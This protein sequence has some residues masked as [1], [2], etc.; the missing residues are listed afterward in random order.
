MWTTEER[1]LEGESLPGT[2]VGSFG[3]FVSGL[4]IS[5]PEAAPDAYQVGRDGSVQIAI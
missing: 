3:V 5:S 1:D 2:T 4:A